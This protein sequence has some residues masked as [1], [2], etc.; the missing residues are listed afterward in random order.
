MKTAFIGLVLFCALHLDCLAHL[1]VGRGYQ[2][3]TPGKNGER[4]DGYVAASH[5]GYNAQN[6]PASGDQAMPG[7]HGKEAKHYVDAS[8]H[9]SFTQQGSGEGH[10]GTHAE[11]MG[12]YLDAAYHANV[13]DGDSSEHRDSDYLEVSQ[14]RKVKGA[15]LFNFTYSISRFDLL[16]FIIIVLPNVTGILIIFE[17]ATHLRPDH[18]LWALSEP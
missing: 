18:A 7:K 4:L 8:Y 15:R 11:E 1:R 9:D 12:S 5:G 2:A 17:I 13:V 14:L 16:S 3:A 10:P 6:D